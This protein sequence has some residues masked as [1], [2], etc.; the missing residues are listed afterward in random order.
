MSGFLTGL[1][2]GVFALFRPNG[3]LFIPV[4]VLWAFYLRRR[5][6]PP[7]KVT[8]HLFGF[9]L[10]A[11]LVIAPV[12]VR[13]YLREGQPVMISA[14][15]G[16]SLLIGNNAQADG[17][18]HYLP[19]YGM[20][21][22][23]F[24]Y[25]AAVRNLEK[26]RGMKKGSLSYA[27]ASRIYARRAFS[28]IVR[29]PGRFLALTARKIILFWGPAEIT[30]NREISEARERSPLLRIIP[31]GFPFCLAS[32]LLCLLLLLSGRETAGRGEKSFQVSLLTA[33][34]ICVYFLSVL[35]FASAARYRMP[36]IPGLLLFTALA[37]DALLSLFRRRRYGPGFF[38]LL[39]WVLL[40][41]LVSRNVSGYRASPA[42]WHY[43]R[44]VAFGNAGQPAEAKAEYLRALEI[45]P[46]DYRSRM[47]L[48]ALL[49]REDNAAGAV[50][51]FRRAVALRPDRA[52]AYSNLGAA[53]AQ[54]GRTEEAMAALQK[55]IMIDPECVRAYGNLGRVLEA[56]GDGRAA[57]EAFRRALSLN[58]DTGE[59]YY[60]FGLVLAREGRID[61]AIEQYRTALRLQP[62]SPD[63]QNNLG[64]ALA[65]R[66]DTSAAVA[67]FRE[68]IRIDP[69]LEVARVN[70]ANILASRRQYPA[71]I[72]QYQRALEINPRSVGARYNLGYTFESAGE[73]EKAIEQYRAALRLDPGHPQARQR[74]TLL[75]EGTVKNF[76]KERIR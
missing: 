52:E 68:A 72:A 6:A 14:Q 29:H 47:N 18:N 36:V 73:K 74:L 60:N 12:T 69:D 25:P 44:A 42:K 43:D 61:E 27:S 40:F 20:L 1:I 34:F 15:G 13:N 76:M 9:L 49:I 11:V 5:A 55:A 26:E 64:I 37:V 57:V 51:E 23:P 17:T 71:A 19:G 56:R 16:M 48:G 38:W 30:N 70:L 75:E 33:L 22:S 41:F 62:E 2:L 53:L 54:M 39:I 31:F 63:I 10:G 67:H 58:P 50:Q 28:Y 45:K 35:P 65:S 21:D 4:L 32:S 59:F 7:G 24:D 46:D 66:G 8:F 3:V